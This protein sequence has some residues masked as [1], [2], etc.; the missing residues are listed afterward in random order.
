MIS[1]TSIARL[2][3]RLTRAYTKLSLFVIITVR[4]QLKNFTGEKARDCSPIGDKRAMITIFDGR[5]P[6]VEHIVPKMINVTT[7][8][9][10]HSRECQMRFALYVLLPLSASAS[11][12][13]A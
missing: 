12:L 6:K 13:N 1:R 3:E 4:F 2:Y 10:S 7:G 5:L 8:I 9:Y 11:H